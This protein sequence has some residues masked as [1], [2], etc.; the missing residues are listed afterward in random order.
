[1]R[2]VDKENTKARQKHILMAA[3]RCFSRKGLQNTSV[4][5][6]CREAG[7]TSGHLY[8]YFSSKTAITEALFEVGTRDFIEKIEH[9]LDQC[10]IGEAVLDVHRQAEAAR[11]EWAMSPGL[12]LEFFAEASR[13]PD[14]RIIQ[15]DLNKRLLAA[16]RA[17]I[18]SG[19]AAKRI[20]ATVDVDNLANAIFLLWTGLGEL[21]ADKTVDLMD[22]EKAVVMLLEPW[23]PSRQTEKS[24]LRTPAA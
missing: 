7:M 8:Y 6:I 3:M 15:D 18:R 10:D 17:A 16:V 20:A 1:M 24:R 11:H 2:K 19:M 9:M 5:D 13:N 22:F 12:R 21:R 14:L 4:Q 23:L